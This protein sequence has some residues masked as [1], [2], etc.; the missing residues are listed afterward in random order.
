MVLQTQLLVV[1]LELV[2]MHEMTLMLL[3]PHLMAVLPEMLD[4][5]LIL[6]QAHLQK[7][8]VHQVSRLC[9]N[10]VSLSLKRYIHLG[11]SILF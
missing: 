9:V 1:V 10:E 8:I 5:K 11:V 4:E 3:K 2:L 7:Q 6:V